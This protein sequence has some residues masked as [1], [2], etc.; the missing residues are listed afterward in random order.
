MT[1]R[2]LARPLR[3]AIVAFLQSSPAIAVATMATA[4][5]CF[6]AGVGLSSYANRLWPALFDS[7]KEPPVDYKQRAA[8]VDPAP[9][10]WS[11]LAQAEAHLAEGADNS[12][13]A[14]HELLTAKEILLK[15]ES[16][17]SSDPLLAQRR[18]FA[19]A[20]TLEAL[21]RAQPDHASD[22]LAQA[23]ALYEQARMATL[24]SDN[25]LD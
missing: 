11:L 22:Y 18:R 2:A 14:I 10:Q 15:L 20:Q 21:A 6:A 8:A 3:Q 25:P 13:Q 23:Q 4:I 16:G 24:P 5:A 17:D 19:L 12:R 1:T 7:W 9:T